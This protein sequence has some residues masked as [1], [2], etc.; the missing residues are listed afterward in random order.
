MV[1][2]YHPWHP[3]VTEMRQLIIDELVPGSKISDDLLNH[4]QKMAH[5]YSDDK[6]MYAGL[7]RVFIWY[8][9][10]EPVSLSCST[11]FN[12]KLYRVNQSYYVLKKWKKVPRMDSFQ[13]RP[14]GFLTHQKQRGLEL[15]CEGMFVSIDTFDRRHERLFEALKHDIIGP[16]GFPLNEREWTAKHFEFLD[17]RYEIKGVQQRIIYHTFNGKRFDD[18]MNP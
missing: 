14:G 10:D 8:H 13:A 2:S 18:L 1:I 11:L 4:P 16:G 9:N 12:D 5:W 7:D 17:E 6:W 15:G 3:K